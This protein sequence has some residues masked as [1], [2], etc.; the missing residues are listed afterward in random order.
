MLERAMTKCQKLKHFRASVYLVFTVLWSL[1]SIA[2]VSFYGSRK[3]ANY[4]PDDD[5]IIVPMVVEK[6]FIEE[7]NDKHEVRFKN[8]RRRLDFWMSQEQ[9]AQDYG[10]EGTGVVQLPTTAQKEQFFQRNYLRFIQRDVNR[11]NQETLD[12]IVQDWTTDDEIDSINANEQREDFIVKAKRNKGQKVY[13]AKSSVKVAGKKFRFDFQ[14]RIEMGMAKVRVDTPFFN[15]RAWIGVNGNQEV[16]ISKRFKATKTNV[17]ANYYI[18]QD[19]VLGVI[20]QPLMSNWSLR[21]THDK[22]YGQ[23]GEINF[24]S[25]NQIRFSENNTFQLRFGMGF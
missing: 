19:R 15:I 20:D 12:G 17:F 13:K 7:F 23:L 24:D 22:R 5:M 4:V 18:E 6:N 21:L 2:Q 10:L 1:G 14:P 9:Y 8:A 25:S 11:M 16:K 3:P